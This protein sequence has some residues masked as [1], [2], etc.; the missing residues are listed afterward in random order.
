MTQATAQT[1][2]PAAESGAPETALGNDRLDLLKE[3]LESEGGPTRPPDEAP[4]VPPQA[5][6]D[7][8]GDDDTGE[9]LEGEAAEGITSAPPQ[10]PPAQAPRGE[11]EQPGETQV[12]PVVAQ[13]AENIVD[14]PQNWPQVPAKLRTEVFKDAHRVIQERV[15][16]ELLEPAQQALVTVRQVAYTQGYRAGQAA[17]AEARDQS[18]LADMEEND[19]QEYA[20]LSREEPERVERYL[21]RKRATAPSAVAMTTRAQQILA[22]V[23]E[24]PYAQQWLRDRA[25][26][27]AQAN[28]GGLALYDQRD[29]SALDRLQADV[30]E[31]QVQSRLARERPAAPPPPP[32]AVAQRQQAAQQRQTVPSTAPRGGAPAP[33]VNG[34]LPNDRAELARLAMLADSRR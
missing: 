24:D 3:F 15:A 5:P 21:A 31:A 10:E 7:E 28:P 9:P 19:P 27:H 17:V 8:P 25:A 18:T 22:P 23:R 30:V 26:A 1:V 32:P 12:D 34:T 13:W 29:P 20:R 4:E 11:Q 2:A 16:A 14:A 33:T 6:D